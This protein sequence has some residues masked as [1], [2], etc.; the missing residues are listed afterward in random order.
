MPTFHLNSYLLPLSDPFLWSSFLLVISQNLDC[1]MGRR[2]KKKATMEEKK[3]MTKLVH[4]G[5]R[6]LHC[7]IPPRNLTLS[8]SAINIVQHAGSLKTK[9]AIIILTNMFERLK[10]KSFCVVVTWEVSSA[11][12]YLI[13]FLSSNSDRFG[14]LFSNFDISVISLSFYIESDRKVPF[15]ISSWMI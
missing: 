1:V 6:K 13:A 11:L 8:P 5:T 15:P 9:C 3:M 7:I 14:F 4:V 10:K 2:R 12:W